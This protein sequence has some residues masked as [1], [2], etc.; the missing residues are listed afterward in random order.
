M[1]RIFL[2]MF[3]ILGISFPVFAFQEGTFGQI[4]NYKAI[5]TQTTT[6][7]KSGSGILHNLTVTGGTAGTIIVYNDTAA[8]NNIIASFSSTNAPNNYPFDVAFSSGCT[9]ITG[10]ATNITVSYL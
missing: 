8:S 1:K 5:S 6:V 10:G 7:V 3:L 2:I 4:W 9:V